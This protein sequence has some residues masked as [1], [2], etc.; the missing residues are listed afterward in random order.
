MRRSRFSTV[1]FLLTV[2]SARSA[3]RR[4]L[5]LPTLPDYRLIPCDFHSHTVFSDGEV[6]PTFRV[7]EAWQDGLSVL[8][9]TDHLEYTPH[10]KDII[11]NYDRPYEIA[12]PTA[13]NY[14]LTLI[15]GAEITREMPPGHLNAI[16]LQYASR[17]KTPDWR[18]AVREAYEQGAFIFWNHPGWN[19]Q[20][21]DGVARWYP[22]Q[23]ELLAA[24]MLHGIEV[25]NDDEY[26]PQVHQWCLE[27]KLTMLGNSDIH[28]TT[29]ERFG[30]GRR[31]MTLVLAS[32]A[33]PE[34][35]KEALFARRTVVYWRNNL[36]GEEAYLSPIFAAAVSFEPEILRLSDR[37]AVPLRI[38]NT[39]DLAFELV[40]GRCSA[41]FAVPESVTLS[42]GS[43]VIIAVSKKEKGALPAEVELTYTVKNLLVAP[44]KGLVV[45]KRFRIQ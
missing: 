24:G 37:D 19:G 16:F 32:S 25:V 18:D 13:R 17:L 8:A 40:D 45:S 15:R 43:S 28:G 14:A 38:V 42:P 23:S 30:N 22:E 6:W 26:Y 36:I 3:E 34:A 2:I 29:Q 4:D 35:I 1:L 10:D 9:L 41:K 44:G 11:V 12:L 33:D 20:Q 39:S 7:R 27:K 5:R 21:P 31:P